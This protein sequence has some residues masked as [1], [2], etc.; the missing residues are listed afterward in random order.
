[1]RPTPPHLS[2]PALLALLAGLM[3]ASTQAAPL[4]LSQSPPESVKEPPPNVVLTVDDSSSLG[5]A[6]LQALKDALK[7]TFAE[8]GVPDGAIRLSWHSLNR[9]R[10]LPL[11]ATTDAACGAYNGMRLLDTVHRKNF[12]DWVDKELYFATTTNTA[13][14]LATQRV[15][16]YFKAKSD[17][18]PWR[19]TPDNPANK[20]ELSCRKS[21]H[22]FMTDGAWNFSANP[23]G[24]GHGISM[25]G[26]AD[27][28]NKKL[29]DGVRYDT[30]SSNTDTRLYRDPWGSP[31]LS[32]FADLAFHLWSTDLRP[33]LTDNVRFRQNVT[34]PET[35]GSITLPP[36]WNP[37]NNPATWQHL[38]T[39]TIGFTAAAT[40]WE[41]NPVWTGDMYRGTGVEGLVNGTTTWASPLCGA[42]Q[43]E[44]CAFDAAKNRRAQ[45]LWHA[46]LNGRGRYVP[47]Q[48]AADLSNAFKNI[49]DSILSES[50]G[51]AVSIAA[52]TRKL[53][54][55]G[56]IY[57][58][59]FK[60]EP[61][62]GDVTSSDVTAAD[63]DV[64][65]TP[66][67]SAAKLLDAATPANRVIMTFNGSQA[68]EFLWANLTS[69]QKTALK[70]S[71]TDAKGQDR[72]NYL[73]GDR[74]KEA[75]QSGGTLRTRG[76]RLGTVVNSNL[77][78]NAASPI[79]PVDHPGH[80]EFRKWV[81]EVN[82]GAPRAPTVFIG[83]ND[84]MLHGFH[85]NTGAERLAYVPLGVYPKLRGY[86]T[87]G[88]THQYMVDG[89][90]FAGDVDVSQSGTGNGATPLWKTVVVAPLGAGGR[91]FAVLDVT[92]TAPDAIKQ[93]TSVLADRSFGSAET[94]AGYIGFEDVGH[95]VTSPTTDVANPIR[96][97]Q[98]VK[99]N[100][101]RWA[102]LL[103]NGVNSINERPVLLIQYLDG[104]R[105]ISFLVAQAA[106]NAGNG[107]GAPRPIDVDGN[108][109][110]DVVY[111]GD[112]LGQLWKF[113]LTS[114]DPLKW[115]VAAWNSGNVCHSAT[116]TCQPLV[117]ARSSSN[118]AQPV[119]GAPT[120]LIHPLG[121]LVLNFGT[122]QLLEDR[123]R[124]DTTTQTLYGVWDSSR[125]T[126]TATGVTALHG[127]NIAAGAARSSLVEQSFTGPVTQTEDSFDMRNFV[128]SSRVPVPYSITLSTAP[129]GWF[130]DLP[131]SGER[132]LSHPQLLDGQLIRFESQIPPTSP[133]EG[134]CSAS[135]RSELGYVMVLNGLTGHAP[136]KPVYY[137]PDSTLD[138]SNASRVQFGNG[139]SLQVES[140]RDLYLI[141]TQ[142]GQGSGTVGAG[143]TGDTVAGQEEDWANQSRGRLQIERQLATPR[144][145]DW[146]ILP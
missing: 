92:T 18:N 52:N 141:S 33:D 93:G 15:A 75:S 108:G 63:L 94:S 133:E 104:A 82:N 96:A 39:Y 98:L 88:T 76:S 113:D 40:E 130:I 35:I 131:L 38:V 45:E 27:G 77:W 102:V 55:D 6:G 12:L 103:G 139:E 26:N 136:R 24:D 29:P 112:L 51:G 21:F 146:R 69:S 119:L 9:C 125:Y 30:A 53:R 7:A 65:A 41:G 61:W 37:K 129:R 128:N 23:L 85:G 122:G 127:P 73:R 8:T 48:T 68:V 79:Y 109:T 132:L 97:D 72:L 105:E 57:L 80:A 2:C 58:A 111:A 134:L 145:V 43:N 135:I 123:D 5:T 83:S 54:Q 67:W 56:F 17:Y 81:R 70:G 34:V 50:L 86:T 100:N 4:N 142:V 91:G 107:L 20:E 126:R 116:S 74:T 71:D 120:W 19:N 59:S 32:T 106:K 47:S 90:P 121:G 28:S 10:K 11:A 115:G 114:T 110:A 137:S 138:L 89:S 1:M 66:N 49:L 84:G 16:D 13:S 14:H 101:G 78:V 36:Y 144:T 95:I 64:E 46:A 143:G 3:T 25:E 124:K 117:T 87:P 140:G 42:S 118:K 22:V 62:M 31:K 99:L 44:A 60:T